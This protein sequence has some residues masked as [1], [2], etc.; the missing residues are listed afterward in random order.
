MSDSP[1]SHVFAM[2]RPMMIA[3]STYSMLGK[4]I[5]MLGGMEGVAN[6]SYAG[7]AN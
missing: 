1:A 6:R 2:T 5:L 4:V 3:Q 7:V